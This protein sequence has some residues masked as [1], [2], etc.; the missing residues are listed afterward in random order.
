[1]LLLALAAGAVASAYTRSATESGVPVWRKD[2][3]NIEFLL[4]PSIKA[5]AQSSD[6][7]VAVTAESD[8]VAAFTAAVASWSS[9]ADSRVRF[10][11]LQETT[12]LNNPADGKHVIHMVD[13]DET[14]SLV[15]PYLALTIWSYNLADGSMADTDLIFN[16]HIV[17]GVKQLAFSTTGQTGTYDFQSVATHELGHALGAN[18]SGVISSSMFQTTYPFSQF[19]SRVE[20]TMQA[21]IAPDDA[22]FLLAVYPGAEADAHYGRIAG[23]VRYE[24]GV[25]VRGPLVIAADAATGVLVGVAGSMEDGA[26][27]IGG[28][29][30]GKYRIYAQPLD[31][32]V[33]PAT[34]GVPGS[35]RAE[36]FRTTFAGGNQA[37]AE[38]EVLAGEAQ[39]V[40][41]TVDPSPPGMHINQ[42][43]VGSPGGKDWSY[44]ATRAIA[45]GR[46]WDILLWGVGIDANTRPEQILLLGPGVTMRPDSLRVQTSASVGGVQAVRFTV[47][48]AARQMRAQVA[49][50]VASGADGAAN[51][52]SIVLL[53]G[54]AAAPASVDPIAL[55]CDF[56]GACAPMTVTLP[57]AVALVSTEDKWLKAS[58][59]GA[60]LQVTADPTGL[61]PGQ[62][63]GS[64]R[65]AS[66]YPQLV[67]PVVLTVKPRAAP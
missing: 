28:V 17:D 50:A 16:P 54:G 64:V 20:A 40:D 26:Y 19:V 55:A 59:S 42:V 33:V 41:I 31:G 45:T 35:S 36:M 7:G 23:K 29:P 66:F 43:G 60:S 22:A 21:Y 58:G 37:P 32:P 1:M 27:S 9:V 57:G 46:S 13:N 56:G 14:R 52:A 12:L 5:G 61:E 39:N 48:V 67:A 8:P 24:G 30:P 65:I 47:D 51:S 53:P 18:H 10:A 49:I 15:G 62:Y 3:A 63:H 38:I 2:A 25:G 11:P 34:L 4:H 6:G 44:A